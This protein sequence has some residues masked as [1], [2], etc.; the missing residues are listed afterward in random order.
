MKTITRVLLSVWLVLVSGNKGDAQLYVNSLGIKDV[1]KLNPIHLGNSPVNS[2]G[3]IYHD[4]K[5]L[6]TTID[7]TSYVL[8]LRSGTSKEVSFSAGANRQSYPYVLRTPFDQ[9]LLLVN[10]NTD[11]AIVRRQPELSFVASEN[12]FPLSADIIPSQSCLMVRENEY[13]VKRFDA[14]LGEFVRVGPKFSERIM[15]GDYGRKKN[16]F[17]FAYSN[18]TDVTV[19]DESS[20]RV[21]RVLSESIT[22]MNADSVAHRLPWLSAYLTNKIWFISFC[23]FDNY[24]IIGTVTGKI[25]AYSTLTWQKV[26]EA[27]AQTY[28]PFP[29]GLSEDLPFLCFVKPDGN[30]CL[31]NLATG[32]EFCI[33][34]PE[35]SHTYPVDMISTLFLSS[36]GKFIVAGGL[37]G[38]IYAYELK[39]LPP[40]IVMYYDGTSYTGNDIRLKV[41]GDRFVVKGFIYSFVPIKSVTI[42]SIPINF[43]RTFNNDT[44]TTGVSFLA[45]PFPRTYSFAETLSTE[46]IGYFLSA[47]MIDRPMESIMHVLDVDDNLSTVSLEFDRTSVPPVILIKEPT[48]DF[49]N[50]RVLVRSDSN[51]FEISG[52]VFSNY[53]LKSVNANG[54]NV[55][56][57]PLSSLEYVVNM[58]DEAGYLFSD[59]LVVSGDSSSVVSV[60]AADVQGNISKISF[61]YVLRNSKSGHPPEII[62]T[63]ITSNEG[64]NSE[65]LY[66]VEG[67]VNSYNPI[68]GLTINETKP[69]PLS[70]ID[71]NSPYLYSALFNATV[72]GIEVRNDTSRTDG[73]GFVKLTARDLTGKIAVKEIYVVS[74]LNGIIDRGRFPL[75]NPPGLFILTAGTSTF[76]LK[77]LD[78]PTASLDASRVF[79][80]AGKFYN[81][82]SEGRQVLTGRELTSEA[83]MTNLRILSKRALNNDLVI[84]YFSGYAVTSRGKTYLLT[85]DSQVQYLE[86]T[87]VSID[88]LISALGSN[89]Q[90][91]VFLLI[92]DINPNTSS[93]TKFFG[94]EYP[95]HY[96][97][98]VESL[99]KI[100]QQLRNSVVITGVSADEKGGIG[101][102]FGQ[103]GLFTYALLN[104]LSG[105]ADVNGD[106]LIELGEL[107][108]ILREQVDSISNG[109][110]H[111]NVSGFSGSLDHVPIFSMRKTL[112]HFDEGGV[113]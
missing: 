52:F 9:P 76:S 23:Y 101:K 55:R 43:L 13:G 90:A 70:T 10:P 81:A 100:P 63:K 102:Q 27:D 21:V 89:S 95:V 26:F 92:F 38:E 74:S 109:H 7:G 48:L 107:I 83:L 112:K 78:Y 8:D 35:S 54:R 36:D 106:G 39:Y 19:Y 46:K 60:T 6:A 96:T 12:S 14:N 56:F 30:I 5:L 2:V 65:A 62:I 66:N 16:Y 3:E 69:V 44:A 104:A 61:P 53:P 67:I 25:R 40:H 1:Y 72:S 45:S 98:S 108:Q 50:G 28:S 37:D 79:E 88:S 15:V 80:L 11:V 93:L 31:T 94:K 57:V 29:V 110:Q 105:E 73:L 103:H 18:S 33:N 41:V 17:A 22:P 4:G 20:Q 24:L 64:E 59:T 85:S 82:S 91:K 97:G 58:N 77:P 86:K 87:A 71:A 49:L 113:R 47:P 75:I 51:K 42:G 34:A 84:F 68:S 32:G 111:M 99:L